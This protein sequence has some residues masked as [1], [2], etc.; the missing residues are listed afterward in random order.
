MN[1]TINFNFEGGQDFDVIM[2]SKELKRFLTTINKNEVYWDE[3]GGFWLAFNKLLFFSIKENKN[4]LVPEKSESI[5]SNG[6]VKESSYFD[7]D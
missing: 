5:A 1:F 3:K 7:K 2:T 4:E 6:M